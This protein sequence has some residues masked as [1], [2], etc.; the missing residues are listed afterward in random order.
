MTGVDIKQEL[1][2]FGRLKGRPKEV[3]RTRLLR[4]ATSMDT[5]IDRMGARLEAAWDVAD[6]DEWI[7]KLHEYEH[8]C[9]MRDEI[10]R[11]VL[12]G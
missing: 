9:D 10:R 4:A 6:E 2:S 12:H 11:T 1:D 8:L 7:E 3:V 5:R